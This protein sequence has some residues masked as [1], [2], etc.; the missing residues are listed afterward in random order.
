MKNKKT[1]N[2]K[3]NKKWKHKWKNEKNEKN[4]DKDND[5]KWRWKMIKTDKKMIN[6]MIIKMIKNEKNIL[7]I[8]NV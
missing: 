1:T 8:S 5:K 7:R 6:A 2:E 4:N 3:T